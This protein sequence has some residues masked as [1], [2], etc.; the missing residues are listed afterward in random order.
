MGHS[1]R[2]PSMSGAWTFFVYLGAHS[3][4]AL[5]A[6]ALGKGQH[7]VLGIVG[8]APQVLETTERSFSRTPNRPA[9]ISTDHANNK[10]AIMTRQGAHRH[11]RANRR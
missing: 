9:D 8:V 10:S 2:F 1:L 5:V 6:I 11:L 7:A 4:L 3:P